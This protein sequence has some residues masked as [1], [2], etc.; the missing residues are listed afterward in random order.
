M[1]IGGRMFLIFRAT[2]ASWGS[3]IRA[4]ARVVIKKAHSDG[5]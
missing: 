5:R 3:R 2:V 1:S 4:A